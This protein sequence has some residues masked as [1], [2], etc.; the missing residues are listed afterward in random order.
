MGGGDDAEC[1]VGV[2]N[3]YHAAWHEPAADGAFTGEGKQGDGYVGILTAEHIEGTGPGVVLAEEFFDDESFAI[4]RHSCPCHSNRGGGV[5]ATDAH[6]GAARK[7]EVVED[8]EEVATGVEYGA[9]ALALH[10]GEGVVDGVVVGVVDGDVAAG[11]GEGVEG[12]V[13]LGICEH[14]GGEVKAR[15]VVVEPAVFGY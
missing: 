11:A 1:H 12:G 4:G 9:G 10:A 8:V 6:E 3:P 2:D 5:F 13:A 15:V 14:Y 7:S